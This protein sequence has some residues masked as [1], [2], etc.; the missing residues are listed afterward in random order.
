MTNED[1]D[2]I[3]AVRALVDTIELTEPEMIKPLYDI[4]KELLA[5]R[6]LSSSCH[7]GRKDLD[8]LPVEAAEWYLG[9]FLDIV[10]NQSWFAVNTYINVLDKFVPE[11]A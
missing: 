7:V 5:K 9:Q 8:Q 10:E 6:G 2:F 3:L 4:A 11:P 1:R